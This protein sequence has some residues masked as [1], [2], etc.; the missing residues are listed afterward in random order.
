MKCRVCSGYG[1]IN[2]YHGHFVQRDKKED[3]G[4]GICGGTGYRKGV[5][6]VDLIH[7]VK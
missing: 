4:C 5:N 2:K 1:W 3:I 6:L 7:A